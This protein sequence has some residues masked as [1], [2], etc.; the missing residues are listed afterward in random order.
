[1]HHHCGR[2]VA[3]EI[4]TA[5]T[6]VR[7]ASVL[8]AIWPHSLRASRGSTLMSSPPAL[9]ALSSSNRDELGPRGVVDVLGVHP[10]RQTLDVEVFDCDPA[11]PVD[12][13]S[14]ELSRKAF[15][16]VPLL[17]GN[18][19]LILGEC[20]LAF[21]ALLRAPLASGKRHVDVAQGLGCT[22][23][24]V[25]ARLRL[26]GRQ[27]NQL[28]KPDVDAN[29]LSVGGFRRFDPPTGKTAYHLAFRRV[30]I[31]DLGLSG[32]A[33]CLRASISRGMPAIS[34]AAWRA[35]GETVT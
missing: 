1:M 7:S 28:R 24:E 13:V 34:S 18:L 14:S 10:A 32:S 20:S 11:K 30:R 2:N 22:L 9:A 33:R 16:V 26:T 17:V 29:S 15:Q 3:V 4:G 25:R 35:Q 6:A 23:G 31:A 19:F 5:I 21:D 27:G 8:P 12:D